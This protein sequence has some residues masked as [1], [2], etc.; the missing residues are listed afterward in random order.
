L[1][2]LV[3]VRILIPQLSAE[4]PLMFRFDHLPSSGPRLMG[5][6]NV[7]PNSFSDGGSFLDPAAAAERARELVAQGAVILD[8]GAEASSFFRPGVEPVEAEEQIRRLLP[9]LGLLRDL[10]KGVVISVD[11]RSAKVARAVL[12]AGAG[13]INDISAGTHDAE[14]FEVVAR[15][16]AGVILM[17]ISPGYPATPTMDDAD[18]VGTVWGY[19][20]GRARAAMAAGIAPEW[21]ALDP[22][23]G[24]GKTMADNWRLALGAGEISERF[25]VVVGASRKR[26][27]ETVPPEDVAFPLGW[28]VLVAQLR[29]SSL[30]EH[31]RDPATAALARLHAPHAIHRVHN[32]AL[33][34]SV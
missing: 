25:A 28:D 7:T 5:I 10:P 15:Q 27:L 4:D 13:I 19:L 20:E 9:V 11:T 2:L 8:L 14:L 22:G 29:A 6:V 31:P 32:V 23:I 30:I 24:F 26:F 18:I 34:A 12:E 17:H 3:Q 16:G 1:V 21:I 33:A